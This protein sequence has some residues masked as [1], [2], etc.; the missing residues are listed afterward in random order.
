[1]AATGN[2]TVIKLIQVR[3][4]AQRLLEQHGLAERG[5]TFELSN[6]KRIVGQCNY[7]RKKILYSKYHLGRPIDRIANTILH[8]IAHAL[9]GYGKGHNWEWKHQAREIGADPERQCNDGQYDGTWNYRLVCRKCGAE[10]KRHR[11]KLDPNKVQHSVKPN[12]K[13]CGGKMDVY[14][15]IDGREYPLTDQE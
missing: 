13:P 9:V 7:T 10:G 1:M 12:G 8:E 14:R 11:M 3:A 2:S 6:Q 15:I 5:W 4:T